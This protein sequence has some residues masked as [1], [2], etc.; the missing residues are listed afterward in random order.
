MEINDTIFE[1]VGDFKASMV[2]GGGTGVV[3]GETLQVAASL[4][5]VSVV[6]ATLRDAPRFKRESVGFS[7]SLRV[8]ASVRTAQYASMVLRSL[9]GSQ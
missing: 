5:R 9:S 2:L 1:I 7:S 3:S 8:S 6:T 4:L